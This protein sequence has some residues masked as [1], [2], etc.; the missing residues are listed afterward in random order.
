M[1]NV[2]SH[3][4]LTLAK[5]IDHDVFNTAKAT[6]Y[7]GMLC[8]FPAVLVLTTVLASVDEGPSIIGVMRGSFD[9]VLPPE[10]LALLQNSLDTGPIR[11][12]QVILSATI[13]TAFAGLGVMLSLMEG[14]RRAYEL[15][16]DN[17][18]FWAK[19]L[20]GILLVPISLLPL[21][22]ASLLLVFGHQIETWMV[23]NADH[24]LRLLVIFF[25]RLVR[26]GVAMTTTV[27]VLSALY[28]FGTRRTEHWS[29]VLP[30]AIAS[31]AIWFPVTLA[32]GWYVTRIANY[33]RFYGSFAA[34]IATLVWLYLTSFSALVGAELNG[35]LFHDRLVREGAAA[36]GQAQ[37]TTSEA[38]TSF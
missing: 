7:S 32:F 26:W 8:F 11:S 20:R 17:W 23:A 24:E 21:W 1:R 29:R 14:F 12:T 6:A 13:L 35:V 3:F 38:L 15:P 28:H 37:E 2:L 5:A 34:G 10:S 19:R 4:R 16:R 30:G 25:W 18:S 31:T 9:Q 22:L 33:T 27:A 36:A